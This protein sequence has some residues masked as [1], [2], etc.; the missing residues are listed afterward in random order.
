MVEYVWG[1]VKKLKRVRIENIQLGDLPIW[2][3]TELTKREKDVLFTKLWI[4]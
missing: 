4:K 2:E 1:T 3:Y